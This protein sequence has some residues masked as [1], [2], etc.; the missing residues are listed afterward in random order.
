VHNHYVVADLVSRGVIFIDDLKQVPDHSVV[1]F[2]AHGV[3]RAVQEQAHRRGLSVIDAT[4][5]L[6]TKVHHQVNKYCRAGYE[7]I[8]I[9]HPGHVEVVGTIGQVID[10]DRWRVHVVDSI[11]DVTSLHVSNPRKLAYVTQTTLSVDD[12]RDIINALKRRFP[13]IIAPSKEDICY[14]TQNR[15]QAVKQ[16]VQQ[17]DVI[18][19]IGSKTSSNSNSLKQLAEQRGR[20]AYLIDGPEDIRPY[21]FSADQTVGI[22]AGASAPEILVQGVIDWFKNR[23]PVN[24]R[25]L[26]SDPEN[27]SFRLP[28]FPLPPS[29]LVTVNE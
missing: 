15:Q 17:C 14:A 9:G 16:L 19:V 20:A 2:S 8:V 27:I 26:Q 10:E 12:T 4:C 18:L 7:I 6:V 23:G 28:K 5:P 11:S 24:I 29:P 22:T 21:W 1:I 25:E 13:N 3:S